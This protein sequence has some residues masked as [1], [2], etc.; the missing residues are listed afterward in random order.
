MFSLSSQLRRPVAP[1]TPVFLGG[2]KPE[3]SG[4]DGQVWEDPVES[5]H[6]YE[7]LQVKQEVRNACVVFTSGHFLLCEC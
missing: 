1:Y 2:W 5:Q 4:P 6:K 7:A 3:A